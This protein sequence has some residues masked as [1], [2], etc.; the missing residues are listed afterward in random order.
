MVSGNRKY[1]KMKVSDVLR[2]MEVGQRITV[3]NREA[4][5]PSLCNAA[6]RL[7]AEGYVF[8]VSQR[9]LIDETLVTR[10]K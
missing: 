5:Y 10:L 6:Y 1:Y 7:K 2:D 9:G 8:A 4:K 3:K